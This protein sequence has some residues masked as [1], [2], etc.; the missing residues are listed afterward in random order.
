MSDDGVE[1]CVMVSPKMV[2]YDEELCKDGSS[3]CRMFYRQVQNG[4]TM[5]QECI[6]FFK[7][8]CRGGNNVRNAEKPHR[9]KTEG[10]IMI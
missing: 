1:L 10:R 7:R 3:R 2:H 9:I 8:G 6:G 4:H 5:V